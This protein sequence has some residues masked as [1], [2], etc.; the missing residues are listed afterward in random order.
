MNEKEVKESLILVGIRE[1]IITQIQT[2]LDSNADQIKSYLS[3]MKLDTL[4][5]YD[6]EWRVDLKMA[7]RSLKKQIEP[8]I[9]LKFDLKSD[10][11]DA[12]GFPSVNSNNVQTKVLQTDIVNLNNLTSSLEEALNEI[13]TNYVRR[14]L[15]NVV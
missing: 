12:T 7:S 15:R 3:K 13:K 8:E 10:R 5:F 9:M 4:K 1:E 2:S 11:D 6:L 14:V